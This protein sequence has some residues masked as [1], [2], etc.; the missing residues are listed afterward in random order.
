LHVE[1]CNLLGRA[2]RGMNARL[3]G[4][5]PMRAGRPE[6]PGVFYTLFTS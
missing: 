3:P 6:F 4:R 1:H 2:R 5:A